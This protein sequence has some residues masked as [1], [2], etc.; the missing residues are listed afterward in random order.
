MAETCTAYT[1]TYACS[2]SD[3]KS[4]LFEMRAS[5]SY[6]EGKEQASERDEKNSN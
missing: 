1:H 4:Y 2:F 6:V 3:K 5:I